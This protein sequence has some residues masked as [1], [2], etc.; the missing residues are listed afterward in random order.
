MRAMFQDIDGVT[1]VTPGGGE[2]SG[3]WGF[4]L[5]VAGSIDPREHVFGSVVANDL[6]LL[7]MHRERVSLEET[8]RRLTTG[9]EGETHV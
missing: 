8:F 1:G 7:D 2:G 6:V 9:E 3:T 4:T 5:K